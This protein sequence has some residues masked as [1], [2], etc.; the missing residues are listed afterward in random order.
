MKRIIIIGGSFG[1]VIAAFELRRRLGRRAEIT[2]VSETDVFAF[3]PSLPWVALGSRKPEDISV[4]LDKL[5][6]RKGIQ[7]L[8]ASI[9]KIDPDKQQV[10]VEA[11]LLSYDYLV[12][13]TGAHLDFAAVSG[14]GP[15]TGYT[16]SIMTLEHAVETNQAWQQYL[17]KGGPIVV[18]CTQGVSCFGPAY[19]FIFG[20]EQALWKLG[21]RE[22]AS[23]TF[24]TSEPYVSHFGLGGFRQA[25]RAIEDE[26]AEKAIKVYTN[27]VVKE[28]LPDRVVLGDGTELPFSFSLFVP[29]F[30]GVDAVINSGLGNP[31][32]FIA[33]DEYYRHN[34]HPNIYITGVA[35]AVAPREAT[36]VPTGV[37]KTGY[38]TEHMSKVVAH[39][40]AAEI[41]GQEAQ[42]LP[43]GKL[44][45][46]CIADMG[47]KAA[48]MIAKPALPPRGKTYLKKSRWAHWL[49][50]LFERYFMF[51]LKRGTMNLP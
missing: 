13:A 29:P 39:N 23:L 36:P 27:A 46:T 28:V 17:K 9:S 7:F 14:L 41:L 31:K 2:L 25:G 43:V 30:R 47:E 11:K 3:L 50:V 26:F 38:M 12:V 45:V 19:E 16:H 33:V 42:A 34:S 40:I 15:E 51:K 1:G 5:L 18:G 21:L 32:G 10:E 6:S 24:V 4:G 48:F 22:K 8:H 44:N 37:P 20:V 49:K 35:V